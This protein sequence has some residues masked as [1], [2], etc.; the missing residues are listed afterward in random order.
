LFNITAAANTGPAK[1][2][3]PTSSTPAFLSILV[4]ILNF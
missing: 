3:R 4:R 2:P 1:H